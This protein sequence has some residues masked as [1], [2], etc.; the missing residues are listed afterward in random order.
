MHQIT[1]FKCGGFAIGLCVNHI[2]LDGMSAKVF[3]ENLASQA[4]DDNPLAVV[5]C[6]DRRLLAARSPP[7]AAF[8]HR[9][10]FKPDLGPTSALPV[11]DCNKEELEYRVFQLNPSD[12]NFLKQK[13][14]KSETA[15]I[16]SLTVVAALMWK[17]KALSKDDELDKERVSQL[18]NVLDLR[19]RLQQPALPPNYCGNALLV[20]YAA[21]SCGEI[22]TVEF[23]E[24]VERVAEGPGRVTDEYARSALDWLEIH[25]GLPFGEYMVSSWLRLGFEAVVFPWGKAVHT[26]P[27]V[28]HRKDICWVFPTV[29]G[30]N[31]LVSLPPP[32]ME[33]FEACFRRFFAPESS[34]ATVQIPAASEAATP[35]VVAMS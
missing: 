32:E 26:G 12:I 28:S 29:Q 35:S 20:A 9:E 24:L 8:D 25:K 23:S 34:P 1:S 5:P 33:R 16:S 22:D 18:L 13:A 30:V 14:A 2:L 31:A 21:A 15:R 17:C 6:F 3:N 19:S 10:F 4:F 11:F 27:I 7:R